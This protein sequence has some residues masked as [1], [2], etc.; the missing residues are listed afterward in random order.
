MTDGNPFIKDKTLSLPQTVFLGHLFQVFQDSALQMKD[1]CNPLTQ[2]KVR[3]FFTADA[4]CAEH[5][6]PFVVKPLLVGLPPAGKLSEAF[7]LGVNRTLKGADRHLIVVPRVNHSHIWRGN[8]SVPV[9][10]R[11]IMA[12][13]RLRVD[14]GLAHGH[15]LPLQ[16]H[17]H[18]AKRHGLRGA[19][20]PLQVGASGQAAQIGQNHINP[21]A[22][23]R[24]GA[25]DAFARQKQT[26][27]DPLRKRKVKKRPTQ[28]GGI[29]KTGKVI[30]G[31]HDDHRR[32][33]A[34]LRPA[35]KW[36]HEYLSIARRRRKTGTMHCPD[37]PKIRRGPTEGLTDKA[38]LST[39][40]QPQE[41]VMHKT[42][43]ALIVIDIQ[44]DF[45][46]GGSL[47]VAQGDQIIARVNAMMPEFG[48]VVLTQDWHPAE[49]SSFASQHPGSAPFSQIEMPYGSQTLWPD[50]CVKGTPGA[51][52]H[53]SLRLDAADLILRKGFRPHV[54]SYSAF[55]ENDHRTST[56][57]AGYLT[58]RGFTA[59]TLVGLATD[60]CVAYSALDAAR[61]GFE[62][63]ILVGA[64]RPI[65]LDGSLG[66]ALLQLKTAGVTLAD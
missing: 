33:I 48:T 64:T 8:Q 13:T 59:V 29:G 10:G 19:F 4:S 7:G 39:Q 52:F 57:L 47:A 56:G 43:A 45:C 1:L 12:N 30:K 24:D 20:F 38:P 31:G 23:A 41:N 3:R 9:L 2:K 42:H 66:A 16:P 25:I 49:H 17:L 62:T 55:F 27:L 35:E 36:P 61:L 34:D 5:G 44:N 63:K 6:D 28:R 53:A 51:E 18:A 37:P 26:T 54:D 46:P 65:D 58:A 22:R 40:D 11:H 50:H 14:I 60:Y 15:D 32:A 21:A